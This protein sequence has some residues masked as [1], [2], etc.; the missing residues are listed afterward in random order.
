MQEQL[1]VFLGQETTPFLEQLFDAINSEVYLANVTTVATTTATTITTS[2]SA[3]LTLNLPDGVP[4]VDDIILS[5]AT[6]VLTRPERECTP[7]LSDNKTK[8]FDSISLSPLSS[9]QSTSGGASTVVQTPHKLRESPVPR[10]KDD[11]HIRESRR[12]QRSR[13]RSRSFDRLK[14]SRSKERRVN[15]HIHNRDRNIHKYR[16]KSPPGNMGRRFD[17]RGGIDRRRNR[18]QSGSRSRSISP[19]RKKPSRSISPSLA[20]ELDL[21]PKKRQ[22]C[23]DFDEKGYCMRGETCPWDHG[24]DPVVLEDI[25]NPALLSIQGNNGPLRSGPVHPEYNPYAPDLF[26]R[27]N[28]RPGQPGLN[29]G[30]F[31]RIPPGGQFKGVPPSAPFPFPLNPAVTPLQQRELIPVP[32]VDGSNQGGGDI[33]HMNIKRRFEPEDNVAIAEAPPKRKPSIQN[34][35]GPRIPAQQNCSLELRKIPRGLNAIAHLNN[36][37]S[38]FGKIINIQVSY[39]GDPEAAIV[40]FSTHA[41]ANVAYRSTEAVLNNRFIKVFWHTPTGNANG[42][43]GANKSEN[44]MSF[45]KVNNP[46]QYHIN[47]KVSEA[48]TTP[49]SNASTTVTNNSDTSNSTSVV[50]ARSGTI[51]TTTATGTTSIS[52]K[53]MTLVN[54]AAGVTPIPAPVR[55][56][57]PKLKRE[58]AQLQRKQKENAVQVAVGLLKKKQSLLDGYVKQM[59]STLM[60]LERT[61]LTETQRS[62]YKKTIMDLDATIVGLKKDIAEEQKNLAA[63]QPTIQVRKTKEQKQ[64]ELLDVELDL[65]TQEHVSIYES[66]T[67][68]FICLPILFFCFFFGRM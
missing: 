45:R 68:C 4:G 16:N 44:P 18:S 24:V 54:T 58:V 1:D 65:I 2:P 61:D 64:K 34:R 27:G 29:P 55:V 37:F 49:V 52:N 59:Q 31:S 13:S 39:E 28:M 50:D 47:H 30:A 43:Q 60:L 41:E 21:H 56:T 33:N 46:S 32:V 15:D 3:T 22:R 6:T 10:I 48:A 17:R 67:V 20:A 62:T 14:R 63:L 9:M 35:L 40:T 42:D 7:P 8:E 5:G 26:H 57:N 66:H 19:D 36:H 51:T 53:G 38:K 11:G 23:R 12:R 25:N